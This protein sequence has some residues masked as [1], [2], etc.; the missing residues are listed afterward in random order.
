MS[1]GQNIGDLFFRILADAA[2]FDV[3][4]PVEGQ[5]QEVQKSVNRSAR[6]ITEEWSK[7]LFSLAD[8]FEDTRIFKAVDSMLSTVG[9]TIESTMGVV[10]VAAGGIFATS[11][12]AGFGRLTAIENANRRLEQMGLTGETSAELVDRLLETLIGTPFALDEGAG[13]LAN[14]VASGMELEDIGPMMDRVADAAAFGMVPL[15][16]VSGIFETIARDGRVTG[17]ELQMLSTRGLPVF[18]MFEEAA[19]EA[20]LDV[21]DFIRTLDSEQFFEL[22]DQQAE[23]FGENSIRIAGAAQSA[24][25]TVSGM[26][27]NLRTAI[28]RFGART[29]E[30]FFGSFREVVDAIRTAFGTLGDIVE[31]AMENLVESDG[32]QG[33]VD[34][35]V[36]L[37]DHVQSL[38]D[39]FGNLG[40]AAGPVAG[41][42]AAMGSAGLRAI[43]VFG[44]FIPPIGKLA[45]GLIGLVAT[46]ED[47][48]NAFFDIVQASGPVIAE[49]GGALATAFQTAMDVLVPV[50]ITIADMVA[51][52]LGFLAD[53]ASIVGP[54][55]AAFVAGV[56]LL[57][58]VLKIAGASMAVF[59]A[60]LAANPIFLVVA[61]IAALIAAFMW[62]WNNI[63]GFRDFFVGVWESI[64]SIATTVSEW[65]T[66]TL[67][68]SIV[69]VWETISAAASATAE[70]FMDHVWPIIQSF[71]D[72]FLAIWERVS[73]VFGAVWDAIRRHFDV[74]WAAI[75]VVL[76]ALLTAWRFL[77]RMVQAAWRRIGPPLL[78]IISTGFE[79]MRDTVSTVFDV[80]KTVIETVLG[81]IRGIVDTVTAVIRGDWE[82]AFE[83]IQGITETVS[84]AIERIIGNLASWFRRTI[85]RLVSTVVGFFTGLRDDVLEAVGRLRDRV[86]E[87]ITETR[88]NFVERV[89]ELVDDAV[90]F[91]LDLPDRVLDAVSGFGELLFDAGRDLIGGLVSGITDRVQ[92]ALDTIRGVGSDIASAARSALRIGSPS[93][94][95]AE[96]VGG[97]ITEGIAFGI[98]D[99]A[100]DALD[101]IER[102]ANTASSDF[103]MAVNGGGAEPGVASERVG[104]FQRSVTV[105]V[106]GEVRPI[107]EERLATLLRRQERL[108][109]VL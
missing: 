29:L 6:S 63:D 11:L 66:G 77:W 40:S 35:L 65:F 57:P 7:S 91:F 99:S 82:G 69:F 1:D 68:P 87:F 37:P 92:S 18:A 4:S 43:P 80:V 60:V 2:D 53:N 10:G 52:A 41:V 25:D 103:T 104:A 93:M 24:G 67:L 17:R 21:T 61:A 72:L 38:A 8:A 85:D 75:R 54:L 50:V 76:D 47:L 83:A 39:G 95:F 22:W 12:T 84:S 13:A 30:P 34:W 36:R 101:E 23:G 62:A 79:Q 56:K 97:P 109:G 64:K 73:Q 86:T 89:T 48:R 107:D 3:E 96:E 14:F 33:L 26:L 100:S 42:L 27:A 46:N 90:Q 102:F 94:L 74:A 105:F 49:I 32:F 31:P 106:Q 45:G 55:I 16:D 88:D 78:S 59:N 19:A 81:V 71:V 28:A 20:G 58:I 108:E 70:W 98:R 51:P 9:S 44:R 15:R 5:L